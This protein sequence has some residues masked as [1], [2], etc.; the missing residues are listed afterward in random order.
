MT[1]KGEQKQGI[2]NE[3]MDILVAENMKNNTNIVFVLIA[4]F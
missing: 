4:C 1:W 2:D 3:Q